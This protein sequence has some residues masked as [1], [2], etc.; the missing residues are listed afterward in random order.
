[1]KPPLQ[2]QAILDSVRTLKDGSVKIS[3]DTQEIGNEDFAILGSYRNC[4]G[5][6]LFKET[7]FSEADISGVPDVV[8]EFK[9]DKSPSQRLRAV[10]H[11]MWE[12]SEKTQEWEVWYRGKMEK[13]IDHYKGQLE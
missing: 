12:Q 4:F 10:L 5:Y 1:M 11:V 7:E 9:T 6:F 2:I 8:P 13:I 3:L